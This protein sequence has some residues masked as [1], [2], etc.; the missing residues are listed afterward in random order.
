MTDRNP[1]APPNADASD[2]LADAKDEGNAWLQGVSLVQ[3]G[4]VLISLCGELY[5]IESILWSSILFGVTGSVLA[6]VAHRYRLIQITRLGLSAPAFTICL[7]VIVV[8]INEIHR[9]STIPVLAL[10]SVYA[11]FILRFIGGRFS[12]IL[13]ESETEEEEPA[14]ARESPS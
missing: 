11:I 8:A 5:D 7:F 10:S 13:R 3:S 9:D 4:L 14:D 1:Y 6:F 12:T 2:S